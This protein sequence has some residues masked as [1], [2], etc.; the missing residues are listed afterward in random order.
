MGSSLLTNRIIYSSQSTPYHMRINYKGE[1]VVNNPGG[2]NINHKTGYH[3]Q[4]RTSHVM[5]REGQCYFWGVCVGNSWPWSSEEEMD[6]LKTR[7]ILQNNW[8]VLF[9][10]G[11][12]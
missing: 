7:H 1:N 11:S 9:K 5:Q 4:R 12:A 8:P 6:K 3:H 10:N 2:P